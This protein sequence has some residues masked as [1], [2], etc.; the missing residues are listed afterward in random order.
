MGF[1]ILTSAKSKTV[2]T[3]HIISHLTYYPPQNN[4]TVTFFY[5]NVN[6]KLLK[7]LLSELYTVERTLNSVLSIEEHTAKVRHAVRTSGTECLR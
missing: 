6:E 7:Y 4:I 3:F 2:S 1:D 5:L